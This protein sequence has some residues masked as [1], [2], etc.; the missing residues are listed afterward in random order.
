[1]QKLYSS[2]WLLGLCYLHPND[3]AFFGITGCRDF[4]MGHTQFAG[5]LWFVE[6][7]TPPSSGGL[8]QR[9]CWALGQILQL[10]RASSL[11]RKGSKWRWSWAVR[12][13]SCTGTVQGSGWL[14]WAWRGEGR[15]WEEQGDLILLGTRVMLE[16]RATFVAWK[17]W[18][19][20][21]GVETIK[22]KV[23]ETGPHMQHVT[24]TESAK[25]LQHW[26]CQTEKGKLFQ[27]VYLAQYLCSH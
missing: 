26:Q 22:A 11:W 2:L 14:R 5:H 24:I 19:W 9:H 7:H 25:E 8:L 13:S 16:V 21:K 6:N 27:P 23:E 15:A 20:K 12:N 18:L 1:M 3:Q 10:T 4:C 17:Q